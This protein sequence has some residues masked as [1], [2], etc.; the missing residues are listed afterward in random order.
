MKNL[1]YTIGIT[2]FLACGIFNVTAT[3]NNP[4]FGM[5]HIALAQGSGSG[6]SSLN[7]WDPWNQQISPC[8]SEREMWCESIYEWVIRCDYYV[9]GAPYCSVEDQVLCP[10]H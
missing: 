4:F 7:C 6:G 9:A 3:L 1:M 8:I 10:P 5:S 2:A